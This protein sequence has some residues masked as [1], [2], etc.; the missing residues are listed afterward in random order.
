MAS[1]VAGK[2]ALVTGGGSGIGR[3]SALTFAREGAKVVVADVAVE[4]GEETVRLIQQ[5]GGEAIF[6]KADVSRAAEVAALVA[7]AVQTYGRLDCA[8]NNA[9]IEG[10]AATIVDY[11]EDAWERVIAINLKGVWLCMKYEIP[12]MLKQGGGAVVNTASTAGLVGYRGGSAYVASKHGV[13]GLTKTAALEYA[14]AGV[15]VNAV[16]PGAIDTPMMGRLTGHRPQRAERMAAAEPVGRMGQPEEIAE[17]VVWL[18]SEA[19]S[20]V[21]GH[22]MAVDGGITAL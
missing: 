6:V 7:R 10:A 4:G 11:A 8:H 20:F 13:V 1:L 15:R 19:A 12:Y 3:A 5:R 9:G 2:V 18:C 14:K 21:T 16:C 22:A 17:A